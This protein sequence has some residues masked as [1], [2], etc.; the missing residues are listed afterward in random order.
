[1]SFNC[2]CGEIISVYDI[3]IEEEGKLKAY[4]FH[5]P[6]CSHYYITVHYSNGQVR[7]INGFKK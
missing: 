1:M 4:Y 3:F 6:I 2:K 5:C 7:I